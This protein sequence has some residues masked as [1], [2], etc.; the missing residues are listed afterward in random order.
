MIWLICARLGGRALGEYGAYHL[1]HIV[2]FY[3]CF[4][5]VYLLMM[6]FADVLQTMYARVCSTI[7]VL[8]KKLLNFCSVVSVGFPLQVEPCMG[9]VA[10]PEQ[11]GCI[12]LKNHRGGPG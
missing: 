11:P 3:I 10:R 4:V 12:I 5:N 1:I 8:F 6:R 2:I 9:Q 7:K